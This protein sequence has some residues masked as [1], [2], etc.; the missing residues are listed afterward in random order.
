LSEE[1]DLQQ[2]IAAH[3]LRADLDKAIAMTREAFP[4]DSKVVLRLQFFP[5]DDETGLVVNVRVPLDTTDAVER[6]QKLLDRWTRELP[7]R[8]Q[9]ILITTFTRV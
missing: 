9:G 2:F 3:N 8:A 7:L 5:D 4:H 6:H 1:A